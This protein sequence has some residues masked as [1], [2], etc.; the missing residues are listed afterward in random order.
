[1]HEILRRCVFD[2]SWEK[3]RLSILIQLPS[4]PSSSK[5]SE[6]ITSWVPLLESLKDEEDKVL[7]K[8]MIEKSLHYSDFV[9][10]CADDEQPTITE[11][12]LISILIS[13]Q[14]TINSLSDQVT[15]LKNYNSS[16]EK[17]HDCGD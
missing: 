7:F 3:V 5:L 4:S 13:Q 12:F 2:A 6:E 10:I 14:K 8:E 17:D 1:L 15:L 11:A 16:I 9:E